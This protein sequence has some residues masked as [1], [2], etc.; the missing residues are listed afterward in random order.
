MRA[1]GS[2]ADPSLAAGGRLSWRRQGP[3]V[4][5]GINE[6]CPAEPDARGA[7]LHQR[8]TSGA[9]GRGDETVPAEV[10]RT[11]T[12]EGAGGAGPPW[13][14]ASALCLD[15]SGRVLLV[16]QGHAWQPGSW[17]LPGGGREPGEAIEDCCLRELRE[18]TAYAGRVLRPLCVKTGSAGGHPFAVHYFEVRVEIDGSPPRAQDPDGLIHQVGWFTAQEAGELRWTFADDRQWVQEQVARRA[19]AAAPRPGK[20]VRDRI[21]DRMAVRGDA[22]RFRVAEPGETPSL[23]LAKVQEEAAEVVA[24]GGSAA[25]IADLLEVVEALV[26]SRGWAA[27][28]LQDARRAKLATHGGF[29][30]GFVLEGPGGGLVPEIGP[31]NGR[32]RGDGPR[33]PA[34]GDATSP[35][36]P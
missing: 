3:T 17:G 1:R 14:G 24:S 32:A 16:L 29:E 35:A 31:A 7:K 10:G 34:S 19:G 9:R 23:L 15:E 12:G 13:V 6:G 20:M 26:R 33:E 4:T 36:A 25:E 5:L 28:V 18:E 8:V 27:E 30:R 2:R 11:G 22:A 21:P